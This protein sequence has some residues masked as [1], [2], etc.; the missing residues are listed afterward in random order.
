M[1]MHMYTYINKPVTVEWQFEFCN[2]FSIL[3]LIIVFKLCNL[4]APRI[5]SFLQLCKTS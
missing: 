1:Y 5:N 3:F 2:A 4:A